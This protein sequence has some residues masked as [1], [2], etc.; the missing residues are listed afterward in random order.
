MFKKLSSTGWIEKS[1]Y[2]SRT[3]LYEPH[4]QNYWQAQQGMWKKSQWKNYLRNVV[5]KIDSHQAVSQYSSFSTFDII[6]KPTNPN[7]IFY[8]YF[9]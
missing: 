4:S 3:H 6:P 9:T 7:T 2:W 8:S 1:L 5:V